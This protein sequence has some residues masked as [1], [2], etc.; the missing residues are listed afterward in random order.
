MLYVFDVSLSLVSQ[1]HALAG[2][3]VTRQASQASQANQAS[4]LEGTMF[5]NLSGRLVFDRKMNFGSCRSSRY[6]PA[7]PPC[8]SASPVATGTSLRLILRIMRTFGVQI[9][10][11][12][13]CNKNQATSGQ[14]EDKSVLHLQLCQASEG[15]PLF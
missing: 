9:C 4:R 15:V 7:G 1:Y 2:P 14:S 3:D 12:L 11:P 13:L 8:A 10:G 5:M 6:V